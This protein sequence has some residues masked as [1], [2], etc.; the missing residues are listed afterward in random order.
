VVITSSKIQ[1]GKITIQMDMKAEYVVL[2][3]QGEKTD[4]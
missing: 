2:F 3:R 4:I 1:R